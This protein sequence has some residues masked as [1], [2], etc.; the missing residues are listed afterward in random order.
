[1]KKGGW[2]GRRP[3]AGAP[4]GNLNG[5]KHGGRSRQ[6]AQA[7]MVLAANPRTRETLIALA[8]RAGLNQAS[9]EVIAARFFVNAI[10]KGVKIDNPEQ[11]RAITDLIRE[12]AK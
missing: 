8:R 7:A 5:F 2:G 1:M 6:L 10:T 4:K 11:A 3:G 9:A 12:M